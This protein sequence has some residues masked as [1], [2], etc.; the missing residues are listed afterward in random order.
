MGQ[1]TQYERNPDFIYRRIVD[2][3][4][5]VPIQRDVANMD[6][7][8]TLNSVGAFIWER[9]AQPATLSELQQAVLEEY[10]ADPGVINADIL[11]FLDE[12]TFIN[13]LREV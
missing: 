6:S 11:R 13:A 9:L 3:S 8:Y 5:L 10:D 4:V 7:I 2:E 12:M 1:E